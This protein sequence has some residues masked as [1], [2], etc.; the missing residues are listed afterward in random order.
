M[1]DSDEGQTVSYWQASEDGIRADRLSESIDAEFLELAERAHDFTVKLQAMQLPPL[2][3]FMKGNLGL[4]MSLQEKAEA[5]ARE[6]GIAL[7][8]YPLGTQLRVYM[9]RDIDLSPPL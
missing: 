6:L 2:H 7:P 5:E 8:L 4:A 1:W 9:G 3:E